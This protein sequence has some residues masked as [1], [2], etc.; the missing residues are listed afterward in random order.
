MRLSDYVEGILS[1]LGRNDGMVHV[2]VGL[3]SDILRRDIAIGEV[4]GQAD[5][6][7]PNYTA[8]SAYGRYEGQSENSVILQLVNCC[9]GLKPWEEYVSGVFRLAGMLGLSLGQYV[10]LM[11]VYP[12][13]SLVRDNFPEYYMIETDFSASPPVQYLLQADEARAPYEERLAR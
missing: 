2:Y 6:I 1:E 13:R 10:V 7:F 9:K 3:H 12:P 5:R 4:L 8:V 11:V